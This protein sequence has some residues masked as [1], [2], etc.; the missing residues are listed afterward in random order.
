MLKR[1]FALA[2]GQCLYLTL[3]AQQPTYP[4]KFQFKDSNSQL[5]DT[6]MNRMRFKSWGMQETFP[7]YLQWKQQPFAIKKSAIHG[8]GLFADSSQTFQQGDTICI[9][10]TKRNTTGYFELDYMQSNPGS[11]INDSAQPN[12]EAVFSGQHIF[13]VAS[14][15]IPP[16][17]EI[18]VSYR[19][20]LELLGNDNRSAARVI[21]YW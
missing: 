6:L 19:Q 11:F 3:S 1:I 2:V 12:A 7:A 16:Q 9:L 21:K 14:Q 8:L 5:R 13:M 20:L 10:F 15:Y 17:T 4:L 18:T